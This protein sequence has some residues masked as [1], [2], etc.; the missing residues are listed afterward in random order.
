MEKQVLCLDF[1][2]SSVR[3]LTIARNRTEIVVD[4]CGSWAWDGSEV[5]PDGEVAAWP[6]EEIA[7]TPNTSARIYRFMPGYLFMLFTKISL[8]PAD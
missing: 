6:H 5:R 7:Q 4:R 1:G 3:Y 2:T 8:A